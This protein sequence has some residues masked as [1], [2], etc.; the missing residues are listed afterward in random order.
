MSVD[1]A[2]SPSAKRVAGFA[3]VSFLVGLAAMIL[4]HQLVLKLIA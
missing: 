3:A 1:D 4:L 2:G